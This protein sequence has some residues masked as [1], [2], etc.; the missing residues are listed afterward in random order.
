MHSPALLSRGA[1]ASAFASQS[2]WPVRAC[3]LVPNVL[4]RVRIHAMCVDICGHAVCNYKFSFVDY[5]C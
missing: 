5:V 4:V 2:P 1:R 3:V